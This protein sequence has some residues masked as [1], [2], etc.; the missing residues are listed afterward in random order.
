MI[1]FSIHFFL[2]DVSTFQ[3]SHIHKEGYKHG[4][5]PQIVPVL[6]LA[7]LLFVLSGPLMPYFLYLF[8]RGLFESYLVL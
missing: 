2:Y 3:S 7:E 4:E 5:T 6:V 8:Y 1:S